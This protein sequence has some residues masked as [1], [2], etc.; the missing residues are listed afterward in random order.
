MSRCPHPGFDGTLRS[1]ESI[2]L[3]LLPPEQS[4]RKRSVHLQMKCTNSDIHASSGPLRTFL[5]NGN[6][7]GEAC[8]RCLNTN[9][10][11]YVS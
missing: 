7:Q 4:S 3:S 10:L 5:G 9:G 1:D 2:S 6:R 11:A 8:A